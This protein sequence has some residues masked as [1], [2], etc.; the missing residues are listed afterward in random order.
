MNINVAEAV[1]TKCGLCR[2]YCPFV[3]IEYSEGVPV[4]NS[5]C[6]LCG[7]CVIPCPVDAISIER[8]VLSTDSLHISSLQHLDAHLLQ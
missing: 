4:F 5:N 2:K 8:K 7:A 1:C 6:V 3:A